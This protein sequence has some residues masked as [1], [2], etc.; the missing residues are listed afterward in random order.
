M[1]QLK[2]Q[3]H[4]L[5]EV[6]LAVVLLILSVFFG[7]LFANF[8]HESYADQMLQYENTVFPDISSGTINYIGLFRFIMIKN[9]KEFAIFWIMSITILGIPYMAYK[10]IS[11]GFISGFFISAVTMQYGF[12]GI[13]LIIVYFFPHGLLYLPVALLCLYRGFMLCTSVYHDRR[14]HIGGLSSIIK[15]QLFLILLLAVVLLI[16]S[17]LEAY[18]G[19]FLLK[20]TL[21]LFT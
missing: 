4:R 2:L 1:K 17:F 18:V 14:N 20:K 13:L 5:S 3:L 15:S 12:K 9:F 7:V 21:R 10:I 8:F 11:F 6:Q 16:G 19:S